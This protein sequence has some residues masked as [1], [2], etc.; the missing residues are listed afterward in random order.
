VQ[1][2]TPEEFLGFNNCPLHF[3]HQAAPLMRTGGV[4]IPGHVQRPPTIQTGDL[5]FIN[6]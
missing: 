4:F 3:A 5:K 2:M 1:T 6:I